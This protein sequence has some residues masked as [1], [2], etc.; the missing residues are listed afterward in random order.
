MNEGGRGT[1]PITNSV[2]YS[3]ATLTSLLFHLCLNIYIQNIKSSMYL[4]KFHAMIT[5]GGM[6][7]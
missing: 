6:E 5:Y 4:I 2:S 7:V 1:E 3:I